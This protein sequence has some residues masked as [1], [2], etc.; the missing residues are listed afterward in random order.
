MNFI[1]RGPLNTVILPFDK[2]LC[3]LRL[4]I[5]IRY[6]R[7]LQQPEESLTHINFD[8]RAIM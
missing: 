4:N 8:I 5:L 1:Q 2:N 7:Y 6:W 3:A